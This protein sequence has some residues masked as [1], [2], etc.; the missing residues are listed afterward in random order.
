LTTAWKKNHSLKGGKPTIQF[1]LATSGRE[2]EGARNETEERG[3][4]KGKS[5]QKR[6]ATQKQNEP[7]RDN[8]PKKRSRRKGRRVRR[9]EVKLYYDQE[10]WAYVGLQGSITGGMGGKQVGDVEKIGAGK[11]VRLGPRDRMAVHSR[12]EKARQDTISGV[13]SRV[14]GTDGLHAIEGKVG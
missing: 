2:P 7:M 6:R 13:D 12:G 9:N 10:I 8:N 11:R 4:N 5:I 3:E 14:W 1:A